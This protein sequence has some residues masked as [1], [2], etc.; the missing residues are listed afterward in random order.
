VSVIGFRPSL[1]RDRDGHQSPQFASAIFKLGE[2][3]LFFAVADLH[4]AEFD[5][6]EIEQGFDGSF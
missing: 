2:F 5:L 3:A 6:D 1:A 4:V